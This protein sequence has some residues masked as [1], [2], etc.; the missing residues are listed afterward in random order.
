MLEDGHL[1]C[2]NQVDFKCESWFFLGPIKFYQ[3]FLGV[4]FVSM[5]LLH[6]KYSIKPRLIRTL[7]SYL[8]YL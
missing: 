3:N 2:L 6:V 8:P 4:K 7:I 1:P 5:F